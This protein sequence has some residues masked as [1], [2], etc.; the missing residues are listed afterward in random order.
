MSAA[1]GWVLNSEQMARLLSDIASRSRSTYST[2][3]IP[4]RQMP[5][6]GRGIQL[7]PR[8]GGIFH[9]G[10]LAGTEAL[11]YNNRGITVS[12]VINLRGAKENT[13]TKWMTRLAERIAESASNVLKL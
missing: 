5:F 7:R 2:M 10:S 4:S 6:Y 1:A 3:V 9:C 8:D 13:L 11:V 12:M